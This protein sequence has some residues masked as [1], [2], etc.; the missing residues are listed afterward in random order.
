[1]YENGVQLI[2]FEICGEKF[3]F[4]MQSLVE[5]VQIQDTEITPFFSPIPIIRG[6]WNYRGGVVYII[7]IRDFFRLECHRPYI[8]QSSKNQREERAA[9]DNGSSGDSS[10]ESSSKSVLVVNI[11]EQNL[12]LLTDAVLQVVA[13]TTFYQYPSMISTLPKRYFAGVTVIDAELVLLLAIEEFV[14]DYEFDALLGQIGE[15]EM[16][17]RS[18]IH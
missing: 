18:P 4:N 8:P 11:Q 9:T 15:S 6:K 1:M 2:C 16:F 3:A 12:G 5:I 14:R 17:S 7:D 13:L 10:H